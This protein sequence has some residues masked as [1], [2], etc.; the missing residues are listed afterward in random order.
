MCKRYYLLIIMAGMFV[1]AGTGQSALSLPQ[2]DAETYRLYREGKWK[3]LIA[4]GNSA[5]ENGM[6]FYFLRVRLGIAYFETANYHR[7]VLHLEKANAQGDGDVFMQESLYYAYLY[8]GRRM[9]ALVLAKSFTPEQK[10][11]TGTD[12]M[13]IIRQADVYLNANK[14]DNGN[15]IESFTSNDIPAEDGRQFISDGHRYFFAGLRHEFS[16]SVGLYHGYTWLQKD[17]YVYAREED[18]AGTNNQARATSHQYFASA[19]IRVAR[20]VQ[21]LGGMHLLGINYVTP[22]LV[23]QQGRDAL[24]WQDANTT[25][26]VF[27]GGLSLQATY[28]NA[29]AMVYS[30]NLNSRKQLQ[31]D[32]QLTVY[33]SGNHSLYFVSQFSYQAEKLGTEKLNRLVFDQQAGMQLSK[34]WWAEAYATFGNM[35]NFIANQGA[36]LFNTMDM[37]KNRGGVRGYFFPTWKTRL[38]LEGVWLRS[39]SVFL[40]KDEIKSSYNPLYFNSFM[41]TGGISWYF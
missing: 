21:L 17:H 22:V 2:V 26:S 40:P 35:Q 39:E 27:F 6:D 11:R 28:I 8:S 33:P 19:Q 38:M 13:K 34:R 7:A 12:K 31:S 32:F 37:V 3:E 9:E 29:L 25:E 36:V 15:I 41:I 24:V 16:P 14:A 30:G 1:L 23:R 4:I 20:N 5:L 18:I 10:Q